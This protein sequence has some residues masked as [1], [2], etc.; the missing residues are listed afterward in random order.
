MYKLEIAPTNENADGKYFNNWLRENHTFTSV[1]HGDLKVIV[2]F[3][4]EPVAEIKTAIAEKYESLTGSDVIPFASI[5]ED[6]SKSEVDG[7]RLFYN[8]SSE[9]FALRYLTGELTIQNVDYIFERLKPVLD[10]LLV[11]FWSLAMYRMIAKIAPITQDD[12][13]N[14]YTQEVHDKLL[15]D[16]T[17]YLY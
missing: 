2:S 15:N 7:K 17:S 11:G 12:I 9:N 4:T 10:P 14:G 8:F 3:A 1:S 6:F 5:L 13:D 16:I